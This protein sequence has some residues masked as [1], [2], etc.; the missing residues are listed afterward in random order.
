MPSLISN[1]TLE[2]C[3]KSRWIDPKEPDIEIVIM[4]CAFLCVLMLLYNMWRLSASSVGCACRHDLR[5]ITTSTELRRDKYA[6]E[7]AF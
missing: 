7:A 5:P 3:S 4:L 2:S 1:G 6:D